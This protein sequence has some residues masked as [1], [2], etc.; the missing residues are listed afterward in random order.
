V[1]EVK[2]NRVFVVVVLD[3]LGERVSQSN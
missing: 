2:S 1:H 3:F